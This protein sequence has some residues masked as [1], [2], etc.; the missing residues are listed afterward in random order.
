AVAS[1]HAGHRLREGKQL[2]FRQELVVELGAV[3]H[4]PESATDDDLETAD[5]LAV[6]HAGLRDRAEVVEVR[7]AAGVVRAARERDLE[8]APEV[9]RVRVTE[10]E[11]RE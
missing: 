6:H 7:E 9:L 5:D 11:E 10:E 8:L 4:G 3:G 1:E 2:R